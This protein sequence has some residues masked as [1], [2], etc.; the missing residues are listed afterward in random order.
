M[1]LV[2]KF[3]LYAILFY[4]NLM[5]KYPCYIYVSLYI[6]CPLE[7]VCL[8][9]Y[10]LLSCP[11]NTFINTIRNSLDFRRCTIV[12][13]L[14]LIY[15]REYRLHLNEIVYKNKPRFMALESHTLFLCYSIFLPH[16]RFSMNENQPVCVYESMNLYVG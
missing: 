8:F 1:Y 4:P 12:R 3:F 7:N 9:Y 10:F 15:F 13:K 6:V 14:R 11:E 5:P 16:P 2:Y